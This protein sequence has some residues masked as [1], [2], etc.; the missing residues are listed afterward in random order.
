MTDVAHQPE[1]QRTTR[2]PRWI[3][4]LT[5]DELK[6]IE[7]F[8][9]NSGSLKALASEYGV[10]YPTLRNR[11]DGLIQ[12][13]R[14]LEETEVENPFKSRVRQ[15]LRDGAISVEAARQVMNAFE[16]EQEKWVK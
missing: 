9:L 12:K 6:F 8:M 3:Q 15:L 7:R 5:S 2:L 14:D 16:T 1:V 10:S 4:E 11:L 13:I